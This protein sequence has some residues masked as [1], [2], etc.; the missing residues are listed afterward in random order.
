MSWLQDGSYL[1]YW[2]VYRGHFHKAPL[3]TKD[4]VSENNFDQTEIN[5]RSLKYTLVK[6]SGMHFFPYGNKQ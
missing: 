4:H 6:T 5:N 1:P 2:L 3:Y